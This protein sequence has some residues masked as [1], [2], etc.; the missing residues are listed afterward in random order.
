[1]VRNSSRQRL[2]AFVIVRRP[3]FGRSAFLRHLVKGCLAS[4]YARMI[5][6]SIIALAVPKE[7]KQSI[8]LG[9]DC[10]IVDDG[11]MK[12]FQRQSEL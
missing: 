2:L 10:S 4:I 1:M 12:S 7:R 9:R 3:G 5:I 8:I 6:E 11:Y